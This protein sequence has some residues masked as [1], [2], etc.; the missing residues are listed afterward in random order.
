MHEFN[1]KFMTRNKFF[2][3]EI[4]MSK[5][6]I[7][8]LLNWMN[9]QILIM[10]LQSRK[11]F[12]KSFNGK[13]RNKLLINIRVLFCC[14]PCTDFVS[15]MNTVSPYPLLFY[16]KEKNTINVLYKHLYTDLLTYAASLLLKC[17]F[18]DQITVKLYWY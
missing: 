17:L 13:E 7:A 9:R 15:W 18:H 2:N 10:W 1:T 5:F 4:S 11:W 6:S 8:N 14:C 16:H 12:A 3:H